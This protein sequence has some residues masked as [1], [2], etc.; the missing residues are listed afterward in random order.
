MVKVAK[1]LSSM[2]VLGALALAGCAT[3]VS[4]SVPAAPAASRI[5]L[6]PSDDAYQAAVRSLS[7]SER[8]T[9]RKGLGFTVDTLVASPT[10]IESMPWSRRRPDTPAQ[11][12]ISDFVRYID[13]QPA[14]KGPVRVNL[15]A[16]KVFAGV[17]YDESTFDPVFRIQVEVEPSSTAVVS[18]TG[19]GAGPTLSR[20]RDEFPLASPQLT[21]SAQ[22]AFMKA[23]LKTLLKINDQVQQ[24]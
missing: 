8:E 11:V 15:A 21:Q 6:Q 10:T 3:D 23:F 9:F 20:Q 12:S 1:T 14:L 13:Q 17:T 4:R 7:P 22:I 2:I 16:A 18:V 5:V 19:F 24:G